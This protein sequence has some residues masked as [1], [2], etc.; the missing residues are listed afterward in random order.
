MFQVT[1]KFP[2]LN[3]TA[4]LVCHPTLYTPPDVVAAQPYMGCH[5]GWI[6]NVYLKIP[7]DPDLVGN[8]LKVSD[9]TKETQD[10]LYTTTSWGKR[11][12]EEEVAK[13]TNAMNGDYLMPDEDR[14]K[15]FEQ[16]AKQYDHPLDKRHIST[17]WQT[18]LK[19]GQYPL[20]PT[21]IVLS[22]N[23]NSYTPDFPKNSGIAGHGHIKNVKTSDFV[24]WLVNT[25]RGVVVGSPIGR[26]QHHQTAKNFS[27]TQMW[28]WVPPQHCHFLL[29]GSFFMSAP[30]LLP[31]KEQWYEDTKGNLPH[32]KTEDDV[33]K[34]I[35]KG[36]KAP[37]FTRP[38]I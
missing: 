32:L 34:A 15:L 27:M 23:I 4:A 2:D 20:G 16:I 8:W 29:P 3:R 17:T 36:G 22:D 12:R 7:A 24:Q 38:E 1:A 14:F 37:V 6:G 18:P 11:Y 26:N 5:T 21:F 31:S 30:E 19:T 13:I 25:R 28:I 33:N 10:S 9:S 35:F